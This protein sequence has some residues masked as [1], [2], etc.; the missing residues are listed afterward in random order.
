MR[1]YLLCLLALSSFAFGA[2][3]AWQDAVVTKVSSTENNGA[4]V[5]PVGAMLVGVPIRIVST[6]YTVKT[7]DM[8][9]LLLWKN[10]RKPLNVTL[11]AKTK[12]SVEGQNAHIIDD[13]GHDKKL[14][15][16]LKAAHPEK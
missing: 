12:I 16:V 14:P 8:S 6:Y 15:I 1:R 13:E 3:R 9:Y 4:A 10:Q 11:N 7:A 5:A 2:E